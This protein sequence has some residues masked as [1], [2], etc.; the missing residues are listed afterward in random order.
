MKPLN[1]AT[2][3]FLTALVAGTTFVTATT[4]FAQIFVEPLPPHPKYQVAPPNLEVAVGWHGDHYWDGH[5]SWNRDE[6][7]RQ[8]PLEKVNASASMANAGSL[9]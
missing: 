6:W 9:R 3:P 2:R 8:H 5:R 4:S 7:V 1:F